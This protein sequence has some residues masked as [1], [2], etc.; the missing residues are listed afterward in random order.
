LLEQVAA[1]VAAIVQTI[2]LGLHRRVV[3]QVVETVKIAI[4]DQLIPEAV[5]AEVMPD[6]AEAHQQAVQAVQE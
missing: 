5:E 3:L 1:Q 6:L 4:P 2:L